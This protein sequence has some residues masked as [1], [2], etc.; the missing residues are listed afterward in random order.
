MSKKQ[1]QLIDDMQDVVARIESGDSFTT[2]KHTEQVVNEFL[3]G[4]EGSPLDLFV[5]ADRFKRISDQLLTSELKENA[6]TQF[7]L[8]VGDSKDEYKGVTMTPVE[9]HKRYDY[10]EDKY[11]ERYA[12]DADEVKKQMEPFNEKLSTIKE[13]IKQCKQKLVDEGEA[14]MT[15]SSKYLKVSKG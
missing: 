5:V 4:Y 1:Q 3:D 10:G 2:R 14:E 6:Y 7:T 11:L 9:S 15:G 13:S 8:M 12:E